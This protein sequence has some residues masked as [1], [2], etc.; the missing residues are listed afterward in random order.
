V[1][2]RFLKI[3]DRKKD[4]FKTSSGK[5]VAPLPLQVHFQKSP[6][7]Q[8]CLIIGFQRPFVT[9]LLVP[10]FHLVEAWCVRE[11]I[12]WTSPQFMVH[13][14]KVR[15]LFEGEVERLN[16]SL[17]G[18]E[19]MRNFILCHE[20]WTV[21]SGEMTATLKPI[22]QKLQFHYYKEIEKMYE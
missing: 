1:H 18:F 3:T 21:E 9:A 4:I 6:F 10:N 2:Q 12:H 15:K 14:I 7:I 13:N 22:R 19:R 20:E 16:E 17:A 11:G 5:Y 8:Q